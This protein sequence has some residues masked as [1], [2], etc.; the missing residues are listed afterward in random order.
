MPGLS[1]DQFVGR[2]CINFNGEENY[3]YGIIFATYIIKYTFTTQTQV[4]RI[5]DGMT[6]EKITFRKIFIY[7]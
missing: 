3:L 5:Q 4:I 1:L 6:V 2:M 7:M